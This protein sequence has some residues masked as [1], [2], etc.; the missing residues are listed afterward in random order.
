[1]DIPTGGFR[2]GW[3]RRWPPLKKKKSQINKKNKWRRKKTE[4]R[5]V[6]PLRLKLS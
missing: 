1:M 3:R 6:Q 5:E 4:R 2:G